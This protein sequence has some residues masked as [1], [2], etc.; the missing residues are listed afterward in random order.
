MTTFIRLSYITIKIW[1]AFFKVQQFLISIFYTFA[2]SGKQHETRIHAAT[3]STCLAIM[4]ATQVIK[5]DIKCN[6]MHIWLLYMSL[7]TYCTASHV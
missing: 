2:R 1:P 3:D 7:A 5:L 6:L 4:A